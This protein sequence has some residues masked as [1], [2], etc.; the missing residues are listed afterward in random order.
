MKTA[1][2]EV[3]PSHKHKRSF[4]IQKCTDSD[5]LNRKITCHCISALM[6][7]IGWWMTDM[8]IRHS[9]RVQRILW[10]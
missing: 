2:A 9:D 3:T 4:K 5:V 7:D 6:E 10:D 8:K 1:G